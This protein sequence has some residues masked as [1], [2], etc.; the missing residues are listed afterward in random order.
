M[1]ALG[2]KQTLPD[3][4]AMSALPPKADIASASEPSRRCT[5]REPPRLKLMP[6]MAL[7]LL[8]REIKLTQKI[9]GCCAAAVI[10]FR[11]KKLKRPPLCAL[12]LQ[13][14][15]ISPLVVGRKFA[16]GSKTSYSLARP[17]LRP[18]QPNPRPATT[19]G[20]HIALL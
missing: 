9:C 5:G 10:A 15:P 1:S 7:F 6:A 2:R 13:L 19:W 17:F 16:G 18:H 12:Q 20:P 8:H 11:I 3:I 4:S 14:E